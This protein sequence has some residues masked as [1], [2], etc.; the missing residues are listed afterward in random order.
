MNKNQFL[1]PICKYLNQS[2][3]MDSTL[4]WIDVSFLHKY[5]VKETTKICICYHL[6]I[7]LGRA[8]YTHSMN[9]QMEP[10]S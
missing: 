2:C 7:N 4:T 8:H 5:L 9:I 3:R 10:L 6:L 1:W